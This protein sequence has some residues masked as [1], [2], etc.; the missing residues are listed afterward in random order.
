MK[1]SVV[2]P[3]HNEEK[4]ISKCLESLLAQD[5]RDFEIV[6]CLNACSDGTEEIIKKFIGDCRRTV[7]VTIH[8]ENCKGVVFA[9]QTGTVAA[10]G[11]IIASAD[12]DTEYPKN[13]L[14]S[15]VGIFQKNPKIIGCYGPVYLYDGPFY[16]RAA[17]KIFY[18]LFLYLSKLFG[19][20]NP[21]GMNFSF[22]KSAFDK[23]SGYNLNLK[24][25]EDV[26]LG[27]R[28]KE[29]GK[30]KISSSL[31]VYSSARRFKKGTLKFFTHHI[32]N[33]FRFFIF[34]KPPKD[35]EDIR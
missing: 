3:A 32:K 8:K 22:K 10:Q 6:V 23:I 13:Y 16:I 15:V 33:Y 30:L 29:Y 25:A 19:H 2:I 27:C 17:D 1:I 9:R 5:F 12:A 14:S 18:L 20:D 24:S 35:F 34:K 11:E 21:G 7:I 4:Y 28:L 31:K 26:E